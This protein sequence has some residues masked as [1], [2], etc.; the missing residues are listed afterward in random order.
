MTKHLIERAD[1]R[2][3][4]NLTQAQQKALVNYCATNTQNKAAFYI[5]SLHQYVVPFKAKADL[6]FLCYDVN[7]NCI[8]T[9]YPSTDKRTSAYLN[10]TFTSKNSVVKWT[11]V[12]SATK[13][14]LKS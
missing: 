4:L 11:I 2:F 6:L 13:L 10:G 1:E 7:S 3:K 5:P 9:V 8:P 14:K 12:N